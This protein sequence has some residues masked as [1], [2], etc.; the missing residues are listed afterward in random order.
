[1]S[2]IRITARRRPGRRIPVA[3]LLSPASAQTA[4]EIDAALKAA[5]Q[6]VPEPQGR[7]ERRLHSG[8][9]QGRLEH[10]RHRPGHRGRQGLHHRRHQVGG[11]D[12][13]DLQGLHHGAGDGGTGARSHREQH[14][15]GR[16]R[17]GLQL[18]RRRR[19]VQGRR[20]EPDGQSRRDHRD[21]HGQGQDAATRSGTRSSPPTATSPAGRSPVNQEVFKSEA[22]TNQ[23]NQA[24]CDAD[25]RL[26]HIK[27][28]PLQATDIY[29]EQCAI[30]VNAR[31]L[32]TMA[33]TLANG[34]QNPVTEQAGDEGRERARGPGGDGDRRPLRRLGQV[35]VH[36]RPAGQERRRRRHHRRLAG[37]VRHRRRSRRRS[38]RPAT[39]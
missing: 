7:Q 13:V 1:M 28:N 12:P 33:A 5:L 36:D 27:A 25:V 22:D 23:R 14:G 19:A 31:D 11:L 35:A 6:Q 4:A 34:G 16:H 18:D 8:A 26:R 2:N 32:A 3:G 15:R 37:Q 24:I 21:Q 10:L 9:G 38:T 29:T 20:D 39:A 17:P 30:S